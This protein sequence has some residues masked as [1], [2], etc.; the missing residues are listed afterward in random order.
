LSNKSLLKIFFTI[1]LIIGLIGT[2]LGA[3]IGIIFSFNIESIQVFLEMSLNIELFSK[4]IYYL[5]NLPSKID[6]QETIYV[7]LISVIICF[8]ATTFPAYRSIRID[9]IKSLKNEWKNY[10]NK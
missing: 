10:F 7:L 4:E 1:G 9:P 5:S 6:I 3:F 8:F 2:F